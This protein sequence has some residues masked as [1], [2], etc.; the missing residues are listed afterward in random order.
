M[1]YKNILFISLI[2]VLLDQLTKFILIKTLSL[3]Q[4]IVLIKNILHITYVVNTGAGFG[5]LKNMNSF[6]IWITIIVIG[7]IFYLYDKIP[8]GRLPQTCTALVLGG[9]VG[10]LIDRIFVGHVID[11]IDFRV[12]PVFNIADSAITIGVIGLVIYFWRED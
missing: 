7:L 4:S 11:F 9:A 8:K 5:I 6:L 12:W 2:V 1:K 3:S 10:N